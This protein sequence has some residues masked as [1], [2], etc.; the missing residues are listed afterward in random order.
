MIIS[1]TF[2]FLL[3]TIMLLA[4]L[5]CI[6]DPDALV[7][8][9]LQYPFTQV[10]LQSTGSV[11][12][13]AIMIVVIIFNQV[14][15]NISNVAA[16]SRMLWAFSRDGGVP[17]WRWISRVPPRLGLPVRAIAV[18]LAFTVLITL[19][20]VGSS[21]AFNDV[22]SLTTDAFF[23]S[24]FVACALLLYRRLQGRIKQTTS[25]Y[26]TQRNLGATRSASA[27]HS[28]YQKGNVPGV[29]GHLVCGPF[30]MPGWFG[31]GVN[32]FACAY[33]LLVLFF[34]FWPPA[35]PVTPA[36][37]NYSSVMFFG[38]MFI[39]VIYFAFWGKRTYNG[40]AVEVVEN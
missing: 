2:N 27:D 38:T 25:I 31:I 32:M 6:P 39:G 4:E 11:A 9:G 30:F 37:M 24:Y 14:G 17:G 28:I 29:E 34:S 23:G 20:G 15:L 12:G 40:P 21:V 26:P 19:I 18:V 16:A 10:F 8:L 33:M 35:T 36:S 13:S 1:L 7:S 5:F 3:G 22:L